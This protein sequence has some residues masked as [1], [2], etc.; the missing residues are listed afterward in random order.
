MRG[1]PNS[2][3]EITEGPISI[4]ISENF[5]NEVV[6]FSQIKI[7]FNVTEFEKVVLET[8]KSDQ[9]KLTVLFRLYPGSLVELEDCDISLIKNESIPINKHKLICFQLMYCKYSTKKDAEPNQN[10]KSI[11]S[12]T[13][14]TLNS[15]RVEKFYQTIRA[16]ENCIINIEKSYI[17]KNVGKPLCILNPLIIKVFGSTFE[18]NGDNAVHLK[19]VKD[20]NLQFDNRK[21]FFK[22]NEFSYNFGTGIY[23][24]GVENFMFDLDVSIEGNLFKKN[25]GDSVFMLD[26]FLKSL[27]IKENKFLAGKVNGL[28]LNK[29]YP[30]TNNT[31]NSIS[32]SQTAASYSQENMSIEIRENEFIENNGFGIFMN[33][34]RGH[35]INNSFIQNVAC[36]MLLINLNSYLE[37]KPKVQKENSNSNSNSQEIQ[38]I[39][40][41]SNL[42][43][44]TPCYLHKNTFL[45]NGAS[46]LRVINYSYFL[47]LSEC[48]FKE[49]VENGVQI[50]FEINKE[51]SNNKEDS[52]FISENRLNSFKHSE[53]SP[54][55]ETHIFLEK[56]TLI[57]NLKSGIHFNHCFV[58]LEN[59]IISD[60][61][62]YALYTSKEEYRFCYKQSK[63]SAKNL[64]SGNLGGPWGYVTT[65]T[66][67]LCSGCSSTVKL[68]QNIPKVTSLPSFPNNSNSQTE[69]PQQLKTNSD[70]LANKESSK[71]K[72]HIY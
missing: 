47:Q 39:S 19:F 52:F 41:N 68:K 58:F 65:G 69:T 18:G 20:E 11:V 71:D 63:T 28:N 25:K 67:N 29:I 66:R 33:D 62:D 5:E 17:N 15:T 12:P 2:V 1:Q 10:E 55:K 45:K 56:C 27:M 36:G 21:I 26:L 40:F 72:C 38:N 23:I 14:L 32:N 60:N 22:N 37:I 54:P 50:E 35:I 30:R 34:V 4:N 61:L 8:V 16:A 64:I 9:A 57:N 6:N 31:S 51:S 53:L 3:L 48:Y 44:S 24:D 43:M 7:I 13:I 59:T 70:N 46:G 42:N 49:N